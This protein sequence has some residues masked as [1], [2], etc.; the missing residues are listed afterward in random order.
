MDCVSGTGFHFLVCTTHYWW[1]DQISAH[2]RPTMP[3]NEMFDKMLQLNN[4]NSIINEITKWKMQTIL[5]VIE[6]FCSGRECIDQ[7][8]SFFCFC[9][10][11]T[12]ILLIILSLHCKGGKKNRAR[13]SPKHL[14]ILLLEY[15]YTVWDPSIKKNISQIKALQRWAA[16]LC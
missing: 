13:T 10:A 7:L 15:P 16:Q 9:E 2:G 4:S 14:W 5:Y 3:E 6:V 8:S 1:N 12:I 11:T